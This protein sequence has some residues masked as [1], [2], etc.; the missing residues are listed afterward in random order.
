MV[1]RPFYWRNHLLCRAVF[2]ITKKKPW[3]AWC[4]AVFSFLMNF[5]KLVTRKWRC[6]GLFFLKM[7]QSCHIGRKFCLKFS[8]LDNRFK[9]VARILG[10]ILNCSRFLFDLLAK[11]AQPPCGELPTHWPHKFEITDIN[12]GISLSIIKASCWNIQSCFIIVMEQLINLD[13][14]LG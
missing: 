4:R 12:W 7:G 9:Y 1:E 2:S 3:N 8:C 5:S 6:K 14:L 10:G 13:V 11:L